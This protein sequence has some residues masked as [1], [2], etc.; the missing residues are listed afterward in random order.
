MP[1]YQTLEEFLRYPFG[2]QDLMLKM[3]KYDEQYRIFLNASKIRVVA[4][5]EV[6]GAYY[7]HVQVPSESAKDQKYHYDVVFRFF[8]NDPDIE[9]QDNF[10]NYY[11][12][13]FSNSPSFIYRYA[14]L[15]KKHGA[16]IE[17]LYDKL[18]PEYAD[19]LPTT[20]NKDLEISFDKSIYFAAKYLSDHKF[21]F[22]T[23]LGRILQR[24][25]SPRV[26]FAGIRDFETVQLERQLIAEEQKLSKEMKRYKE[27][28]RQA[29]PSTSR[30]HAIR[31]TLQNKKNS[32]IRVVTK[33][34]ATRSTSNT[35]TSSGKRKKVYP[36]R[37]TYR[38]LNS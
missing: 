19:T 37:T 16:L 9:K 23:K 6:E 12:Q 38:N 28:G 10:R 25:R 4:F 17:F 30:K 1:Q 14:V 22:M 24:K 35:T 27:R 26:F 7:I 8:T 5:T 36:K 33:Q 31:D 13:F 11:V 2:R 15:Y 32:G 34:T 21:R 18:N 29:P 20:S 3:H